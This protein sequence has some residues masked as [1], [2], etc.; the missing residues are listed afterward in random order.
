MAIAHGKNVILWDFVQNEERLLTGHDATVNRIVFSRDGRFL[1]TGSDDGSGRTWFVDQGL[2][3]GEF[4]S[5]GKR[6][7][8]LMP[9]G[10]EGAAMAFLTDGT[11]TC[12]EPARSRMSVYLGLGERIEAL[13]AHPKQ[14]LVA[15]GG[16]ETGT[17]FGID[18]ITGREQWSVDGLDGIW[19]LAWSPSGDR[20]AIGTQHEGILM[21]DP[22]KGIVDRFIDP[23]S[24]AE[25]EVRSIEW[26]DDGQRLY[27]VDNL[28]YAR[29]ASLTPP[30]ILWESHVAPRQYAQ[31]L[32]SA[33]LSP[34]GKTLYVA[35]D[36]DH[37]TALDA[38]SGKVRKSWQNVLPEGLGKGVRG[39]LLENKDVLLGDVWAVDPSPEGKR[40]LVTGTDVATVIDVATQKTQMVLNEHRATVR[41][42]YWFDSGQRIVTG[43]WD[44]KVKV[45]D[46]LSGLSLL[47][48]DH[49]DVEV[50]NAAFSEVARALVT[51][52]AAG[53]VRIWRGKSNPQRY[54]LRPERKSGS[55][56]AR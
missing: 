24:D 4:R 51:S 47:E 18:C 10:E 30:R 2:A 15:A 43:G 9:I 35:G 55:S 22:A 8:T 14:P 23:Y 27:W 29:C 52:D 49:G 20:L 17:I 33:R 45:W 16:Y 54:T 5:S 21:L 6:I 38:A 19:E 28:G 42:A 44:G 56:A 13:A 3:V 32:N 26:S 46:A 1:V 53:G 7:Q 40:L 12:W 50:R 39:Q 25:I 48:F 11:V 36:D 31:F 41:F 34:D 37:V